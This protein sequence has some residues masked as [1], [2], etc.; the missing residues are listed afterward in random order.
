MN[1]AAL[2]SLE[3]ARPIKSPAIALLPGLFTPPRPHPSL[4]QLTGIGSL[5]NDILEWTQ[6]AAPESMVALSRHFII[7][8]PPGTAPWTTGLRNPASLRTET[9]T[10][11]D[12]TSADGLGFRIVLEL[13]PVHAIEGTD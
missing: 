12:G 13:P 8:L 4:S 5:G 2:P 9:E 1:S 6:E 10:T 7:D 11:A 3:A